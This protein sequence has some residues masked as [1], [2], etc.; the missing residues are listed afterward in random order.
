MEDQTLISHYNLEASVKTKTTY[1]AT[2]IF[3]PDFSYIGATFTLPKS[4][5]SFEISR[6][7]MR[8]CN[9]Q[10]PQSTTIN[11]LYISRKPLTLTPT[12]TGFDIQLHPE[13]TPVYIDGKVIYPSTNYSFET[14]DQGL[15]ID[16]NRR[17]FVCI[18]E[19]NL[20][21]K[22][23]NQLG[24][25]GISDEIQTIRNSIC[26][27]ADTDIAVLIRGES[28]TG[29]ELVAQALHK[30]SR[31][32]TQTFVATNM[33]AIAESLVIAELFGVK[34]GAF[35]GATSDKPGFFQQADKGTLFLDEIG[36]ARDDLQ[37]ALLRAL[38]SGEIRPVGANSNVGIDVRFISAT[39][40]CLEDKLL[41]KQ[42]RTPL[43]QRLAGYEIW[44]A[45]LR[46][47][48]VDIGLLLAKFITDYCNTLQ[49]PELLAEK[50]SQL[51]TFWIHFFFHAIHFSWPGNI[52]QLHNVVQ[53]VV[54]HNRGS[55][56]PTL[57]EHIVRLFQSN[58]N[59]AE[60]LETLP[61]TTTS[62]AQKTDSSQAL[63]NPPK[64]PPEKPSANRKPRYIDDKELIQAFENN[65]Y[66]L[67]NTAESLG[68]SR[69]SIYK[70][71]DSN[72]LFRKAG[73]LSV[74]EIEACFYQKDGDIEQ[75]VGVLKV[76]KFALKRRLKEIQLI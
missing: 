71:V 44:L 32:K 28:G 67:K 60:T 57:P 12:K 11:D 36:D 66:D 30:Q 18:H 50:N 75:M 5:Q 59:T 37:L 33:S 1:A 4:Q 61:S 65:R 53:Q 15:I 10:H 9:H 16:F 34:K 63:S 68:I 21:V 13:S 6:N 26:R 24:M 39:D 47:R 20:A 72:P 58:I 42:F 52:R 23:S 7:S 17:V 2:I 27:V 70:L 8:F 22:D 54:I 14:N 55:S 3:H 73:D 31:R 51:V 40:A 46:Q 38:E 45:P 64:A 69:A 48:R 56:Q 19:K 76:S 43:L 41:N 74:E 25:L 49:C 62:A 35:T 29:K